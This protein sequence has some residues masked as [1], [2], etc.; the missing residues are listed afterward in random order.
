MRRLVMLSLIPF[1]ACR[2]PSIADRLSA[3]NW[4]DLTY[5]FDS[6]T[7]YWPTAQP[8]HLTVISARRLPAGYYYAANNLS[9]AEHGGTHLDAPVH[10]VEKKHSADQIPL[11]Q[12][13]GPAV[14]IDVTKQADSSADFRVHQSDI[15][16]WEAAHGEIPPDA[17]VLIRTGWGSRWPDRAR[18]LGTTKTGAAGVAEL[19]FPG[20]DLDAARALVRR[21]VKAVGI[22]TP[23]IDYG[24]STTF[25][26]HR[27]LFASNVPAFE[28]VAQLDKLPVTGAIVIALPMKIS[29]GSGGPLRIVA[30]LP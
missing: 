14:V 28:N 5:A 1:L 15:T 16:A 12:L 17:I 9:A 8:F 30:L 23:S 22:D 4:I 25:V 26:V 24:Q 3:G 20:L 21:K 19:H 2:T 13:I 10:F 27:R 7:I 29:G 6:T 11:S 18:Y